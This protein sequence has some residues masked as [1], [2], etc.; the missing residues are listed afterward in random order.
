MK[1]FFCIL[2][3]TISISCFSQT[4][5]ELNEAEH[6]K[7]LKADKEL[8]QVYQQ[9][10]SEYKTDTVF[11]KNLKKAQKIWIQ[12]RDAEMEMMYP[13]RE[14]GYYG[15]VHSMCWSIYKTELTNERIKKL[16]IWLVGEEEGDSCSTSI[17]TKQ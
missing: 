12:F 3:T 17:K 1:I 2:F 6:K 4:Q 5:V 13:E 15:S 10:L 7:F 14:P 16:R 8:N 11:I 9:I